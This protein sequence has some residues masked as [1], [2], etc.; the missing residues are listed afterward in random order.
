MTAVVGQPINIS[1][2]DGFN[3]VRFPALNN[4][5]CLNLF[6]FE[7]AMIP[8]PGFTEILATLGDENAE[9]RGIFYSDVLK[10]C[11]VVIDDTLFAI[12]TTTF[13]SL[14]QLKTSRGKVFFAENGLTT[15]PDASAGDPGAQIAISDNENIYVFTLDNVFDIAVDDMGDPIPFIPGTLAYQ[16]GFFFINDL[17]SDRVYASSINDAREWPEDNFDLASARTRSCVA[18][19]NLLYIFAKDTTNLFYS[20]TPQPDFPYVPDSSRAW[21]YGCLAPGSVAVSL[22]VICWL[23]NTRYGNPTILVSNGGD[24]TSISTPGIDALINT[25]KTPKDAEGFIYEEDGH[26]FYQINFDQDNSSI[27]YD[28]KS[29][30][31]TALTDTQGLN[32]SAIRQ[33]AYYEETNTLL[34]IRADR[35]KV[36]IFG[37]NIFNGNGEIIPRSIITTNMTQEERPMICQELDLQIEQGV[38]DVIEAAY[39]EENGPPLSEYTKGSRICLSISKDRGRTFPINRV[40]DLGQVG[41]RKDILRWRKLGYAR[42]WTFKFDF[43]SLNRFVIMKATGWFQK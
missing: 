11:I 40:S 16:N 32:K 8:T 31:W 26:T 29:K 20:G 7:G 28:F 15:T 2:T 25:F 37:V 27:L 33:S 5:T 19:K 14:G 24:P 38:N 13:R 1:L 4:Q 23:S 17:N 42:W 36:V 34:A 35:G 10:Q 22:G 6:E 43:F 3:P 12:T 30:K 21:E 9:A 18:F 39:P 41:F